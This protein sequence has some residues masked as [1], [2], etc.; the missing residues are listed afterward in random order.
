MLPLV[1]CL[2]ETQQ[3]YENK[4]RCSEWR[5]SPARP[6]EFVS[7]VEFQYTLLLIYFQQ[8][9]QIHTENIFSIHSV[10]VLLLPTRL[11]RNDTKPDCR[12]KENRKAKAENE[13]KKEEKKNNMKMFQCS[14]LY[15]QSLYTYSVYIFPWTFS[16]LCARSKTGLK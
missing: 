7:F 2:N 10:L 12:E 5:S 11:R 9:I 13:M 6:S 1:V 16:V 14:A 3:R 4:N 8:Y 15:T